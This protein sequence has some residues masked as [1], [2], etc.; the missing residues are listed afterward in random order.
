[1]KNA[2][3]KLIILLAM[4]GI[5]SIASG[6]TIV[7]YSWEDSGTTLGIYPDAALPSIIATNVAGWNGEPVHSG[8]FSLKLEDNDPSGTPQAFVALFWNLRD[9]DQ[10]KVAVRWGWNPRAGAA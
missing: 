7:D 9:G 8:N 1:M 4:C 3:A 10:I 5:A 6:T 2:H